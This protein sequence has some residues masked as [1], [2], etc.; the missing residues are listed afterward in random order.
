M[1]FGHRLLLR[2]IE[3][4]GEIFYGRRL[5]WLINT[6]FVPALCFCDSHWSHRKRGAS[7]NI[8]VDERTE[9]NAFTRVM[10]I[11]ILR[12][13]NTEYMHGVRFE[14]TIYVRENHR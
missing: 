1:E 11:G 5:Y 6:A 9:T 13:F 14:Y 7:L 4:L 3:K 12:K 8:T 2:I 10:L